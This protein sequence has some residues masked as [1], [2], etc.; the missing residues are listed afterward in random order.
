[1]SALY[2]KQVKLEK[3][4]IVDFLN[5]SSKFAFDAAPIEM[6]LSFASNKLP[7]QYGISLK[8]KHGECVVMGYKRDEQLFYVDRTKSTAVKFHDQFASIQ[9]ASY[10]P[11]SQTM[12]WRILL[13]VGSVELFVGDK[14]IV[15]Y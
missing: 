2:K 12:Q 9:T 11:T 5:I 14:Q 1:M 10:K 13:D 6:N 7:A 4:T 3:T 8:N 15:F